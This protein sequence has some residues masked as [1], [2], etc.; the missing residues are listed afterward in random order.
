VDIRMRRARRADFERIWPATVQTVWDDLPEDERNRMARPAWDEH[1]RKK[2]GPYIGGRRTEAWIAEDAASTFLGYAIVG[3]G[4]GFLTPEAY[5]F[6]YDV[7]VAPEHRGK[8]VG[9]FLVE[10]SARWARERGYRKI[11]L[12]VAES[13]V[14]ARGLYEEIGFR[15]ERRYM[16]KVLE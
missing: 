12:E 15:T 4:G 3:P 2:I 11:K 5:A 8:G 9:R 10:W 7:W 16:G 14:R 13:N 6:L 1:F